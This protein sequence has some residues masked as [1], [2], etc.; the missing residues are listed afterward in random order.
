MPKY[1]NGR[2]NP[3]RY[4]F[5]MSGGVIVFILLGII[6]APMIIYGLFFEA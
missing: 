5:E 4:T 3:G 6:I 1:T 2:E